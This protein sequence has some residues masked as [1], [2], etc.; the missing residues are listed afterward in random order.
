MTTS[1]PDA[2]INW[3]LHLPRPSPEHE[4]FHLNTG[5]IV[6]FTR[7]EYDAINREAHLNLGFSPEHIPTDTQLER[8]ACEQNKIVCNRYGYA[9]H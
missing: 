2:I 6:W 7:E 5:K 4:P 9:K 8:I 1:K 3:G